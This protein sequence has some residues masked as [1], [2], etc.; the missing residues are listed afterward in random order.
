MTRGKRAVN[1][2]ISDKLS[3]GSFV[4]SYAYTAQLKVKKFKVWSTSTRM[5]K[6]FSSVPSL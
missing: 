4:T 2:P 1:F 5:Q 3:T 6:H